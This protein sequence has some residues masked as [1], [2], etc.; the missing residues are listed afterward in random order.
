MK[1]S[2]HDI[3]QLLELTPHPEGGFYRETYRSKISIAEKNLPVGFKGDRSCLSSIYYLLPSDSFSAFHRIKQDEIWHFYLGSTLSLHL[4][5]ETG[6][7]RCI[8]IGNKLEQENLLQFTVPAGYW[9]AAEVEEEDSFALVGCNVAPGFDFR[10]FEL[11]EQQSLSE[12]FPQ[13]SE[14]IGRLTRK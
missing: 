7:Y 5:S 14:L 8:L 3:V 9:F 1:R 6:E 12:Q 13:H 11:A 10:D 2:M 4:I